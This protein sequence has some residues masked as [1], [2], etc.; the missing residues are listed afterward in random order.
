MGQAAVPAAEI[1]VIKQQDWISWGL[2]PCKGTVDETRT[3][4]KKGGNR[5]SLRV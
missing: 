3:E 4:W 5:G 1:I 2:Q